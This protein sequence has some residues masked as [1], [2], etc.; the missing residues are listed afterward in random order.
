MIRLLV[1]LFIIKL[2][3]QKNIFKYIKKKHGQNIVAL[4]R[5]FEQLKDK[6]MKIQEDITFIKKC[7][8]E[9]IIPTFAKVKLSIKSGN[10]KLH[11][12]IARIVMETELQNKHQQKKKIKK[13]ISSISFQLKNILGLYLYHAMFHHINIAVKSRRK[14]IRIRH[15]KK[16]VKFRQKQ[17]IDEDYNRH[18]IAKHIMHNFSS[19]TLTDIE[20]KAL[21]FGLDH[22]IPLKVNRTNISTEF[23]YFY[24]TY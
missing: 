1:I 20:I 18:K 21:S 11:K 9:N 7:K 2:Y 5:T 10:T 4:V 8:L 13:E 17:N 24:R 16:L 6:Y 23:E 22:Q 3:A 19:Y 12:R 14:S 15:E